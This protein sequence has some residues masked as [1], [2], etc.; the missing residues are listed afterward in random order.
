M[1]I[2]NVFVGVIARSFGGTTVTGRH[3]YQFE[4]SEQEMLPLAK[5]VD[6]LAA[7]P[8]NAILVDITSSQD[9]ADQYPNFLSSGVNIITPNKKAFAGSYKL[10]QDV[11]SA[12]SSSGAKIYHES[13]VCAGLPILS[14]LKELVDTGDIIERI[15]GSAVVKKAMD[16]GYTEPDPRDDLNGL[17]VARKLTVLARLSGLPV[18]SHTLFPVQSL[19]PKELESCTSGEEFM[20]KL[21]EYDSRME[22]IKSEAE[23]EG[24]AVRHVGS[25]DIQSKQVRVGLEKFD[26]SDPI[27]ALRGN[28]N[29]ISFHTRRYGASPLIIQG[30]GAGGDLTAMGITGDLIKILERSS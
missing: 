28:D 12:A 1:A 24:K 14:T 25:I 4:F 22:E 9:V 13:S 17:D 15:D 20:Q 16:L 19:I 3:S 8:G 23:K 2:K 18:Q 29:A 10:W 27:A 26:K 6:Y 30:A 7:A 11:F 21:H 5:V